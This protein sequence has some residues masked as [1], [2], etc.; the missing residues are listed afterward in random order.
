QL[1]RP[2]PQFTGVTRTAPAYGNSHYHSLQMQLEKRTSGGVTALVSYTIAKNIG[3]LTNADNAYDRQRE[4][5]LT[6]FDVPQRLTVSATWELPV[7]RGRHFGTNMSR[8]FD[9]AAGGWALSTFDTFQAGFPLSFSLARA[10]SGANSSRP[11]AIGNPAEGVDGAIVNRLRHY[12]NTAAFAQ[13]P[14]FTY[15]NVSPFI[16]TVRSPGMN[17]IDATL[18]K[19]FNVFEKARVEFRAA[20]FNVPNHPVFGAPNTQFGNAAFGVVSSQ[21]NLSRQMEFALKVLF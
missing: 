17:N 2:Y 14:D 7:G 12:F 1:L 11:N 21:V 19:T 18:H 16:G 13:P 4:R 9:L 5:G 8:W 20:M 10:T 3:D 6:S 15:G